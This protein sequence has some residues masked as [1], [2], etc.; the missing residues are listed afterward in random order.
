MQA[1]DIKRMTLDKF[2]LEY[3]GE[4]T[5]RCFFIFVVVF[6]FLK[7]TGRRGVNQLS[8][9]E[10][11][12]ILTLGSAAGDVTFYDDVPLLPVFA[13]FFSILL[14]YRLSTW[15]MDKSRH[16][17]NW[18]EG[19][20]LIII[21]DGMFEWETMARENITKGEFY[22]ELRQKGVEHL[23][24]VRLAF[25]EA[26]GGLSVYFR[27]DGDVEPGLPVL[28][29]DYIDIETLMMTSGLYACHRCSLIK[30]FKVGEK[31]SCPRCQNITWVRALSTVRM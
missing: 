15:L 3:L 22:M 29:E 27:Q 6:I 21:R 14:L 1:F 13:V 10:V 12:I 26:N 30:S 16:F 8:L 4:V 23:G 11:V 20:P 24:Q 17:Q 9:F 31:A 25:L 19:K 5:F 18:M 28:P 7:L 2:P